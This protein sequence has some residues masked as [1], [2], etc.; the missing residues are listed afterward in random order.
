MECH[1]IPDFHSGSSST[2]D[3]PFASP[4]NQLLGKISISLPTDDWL[5]RKLEALNITLT[6]GYSSRIYEISGLQ[7]DQFVKPPRSQNKWWGWSKGQ[8][9]F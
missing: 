9:F 4:R 5:C 1:H 2:D 3:N 7:K 6:E 8:K